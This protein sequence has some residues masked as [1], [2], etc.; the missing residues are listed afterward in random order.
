MSR[1]R[2]PDHALAVWSYACQG[3]V[4]LTILEPGLIAM[5]NCNLRTRHLLDGMQ[6]PDVIPMSVSDQDQGNF[7]WVDV[8]RLQA[9]RK[10]FGTALRA[11]IDQ[12]CPFAA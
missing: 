2:E 5:V 7:L 9:T 11:G 8:Q 4:G 3:K 12:H 1:S 10:S 6:R